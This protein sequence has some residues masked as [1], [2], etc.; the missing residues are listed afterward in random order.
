MYY[1]R[2]SKTAFL[3]DTNFKIVRNGIINKANHNLVRYFQAGFLNAF[4]LLYFC[5]FM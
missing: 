5:R 4:Y 2:E 1:E 3:L